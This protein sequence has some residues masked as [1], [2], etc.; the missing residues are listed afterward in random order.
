MRLALAIR[1]KAIESILPA[2]HQVRTSRA[3][4]TLTPQSQIVLRGPGGPRCQRAAERLAE[5]IA[6]EFGLHLPVRVEPSSCRPTLL[7]LGGE[8]VPRP[9]RERIDGDEAYRLDVTSSGAAVQA[10]SSQGLLWG[11]MTLRQL[12]VRQG[13]RLAVCG[14]HIIDRPR[15]PWRAFMID[16]G[17]APNSVGQIKRIIRLCST[18]KLN[19]LIFRE[20]DDELCAV[21]YRTNPLGSRHAHALTVEQVRDIIDYGADLG[22]MV[23]PEIESLGHSTA[24]GM[25]YPELVSGGFEEVYEDLVTHIRKAH[26]APADP[27]SYAV[28]ESICRE[29]LEM[30]SGPLMHLGLDEVR[31]EAPPQAAHLSGLLPLVFR[32]AAELGKPVRPIVWADAPPTPEPYS[33]KVIRCLWSYG[34]NGDISPTNYL[35]KHQQF[36]LLASDGR[37]EVFMAAGSSAKH[38]PATKLNYPQA[39]ANFDEWSIWGNGRPHV[40]GLLAVQWGTNELD[41]WVP[42]FA[43]AADA[44]WTPPARVRDFQTQ[45]ARVQHHLGRL[46]DFTRPR[47]DEIDPPAWDGIWLRDGKWFED[48]VTGKRRP[49]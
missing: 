39:F 27:R 9:S 4:L 21:R 7:L 33:D 16:A 13:D 3:D 32:V 22:V 29:W 15:Y 28:L 8:G 12:L 26:L 47:P 35:L 19:L 34:D 17:R 24:K 10:N 42:D 2:P 40:T 49:E 46:N 14:C 43:A 45:M 48:I 41:E 6:E 18:M 11:A 31:L 44:G 25:Y 5:L 36:E 23:A 1:R 20:G 37:Q 38:L 30:M